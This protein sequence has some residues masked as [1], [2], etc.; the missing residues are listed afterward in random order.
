MATLFRWISSN[1]LLKVLRYFHLTSVMS[2]LPFLVIQIY[3]SFDIPNKAP[4]K[5]S[6]RTKFNGN[7]KRK[8]FLCINCKTKT[9]TAGQL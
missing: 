9:Y 8:N 2:E 4:S 1:Q 7:K 3:T 5:F 6:R